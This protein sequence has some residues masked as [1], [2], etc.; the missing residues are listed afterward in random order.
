MTHLQ[1]FQ[2]PLIHTPNSIHS[3]GDGKLFVTNDH[4]I[5]AAV[6]PLLSKIE[7]F[8]GVPLGRVVYTDVRNPASTKVV[9]SVSFANGIAM[10]NETTLAV[11]STGKPAIY[12][13]NVK[14]DYSLQFIKYVRVP[15][16]IDNLSVDSAGVLLMAGHPMVPATMK[17][18]KGRPSCNKESEEEAEREACRCTAPG[19]VAEWTEEKGLR[20]LYKGW[21]FCTSTTAVRD[22]KRGVGFVSGLYAEGLMSFV[23]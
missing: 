5:R 3:L 18:A 23:E 14:P 17:V 21:D 20:T 19:W 8:S 12:F 16:A 2:H 1:T 11:A 7:T 6:S 9:A 15:A 10:L 22:R 4:Y 13:Y